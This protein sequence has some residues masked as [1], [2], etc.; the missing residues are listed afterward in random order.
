[1]SRFPRLVIC[2]TVLAALLVRPASAQV[3]VNVNVPPNPFAPAPVALQPAGQP[4]HGP[5][6]AGGYYGLPPELAR[7]LAQLEIRRRLIEQKRWEEENTP[8]LETLR[9]YWRQLAVQ[10]SLNDPPLSEIT[11]G[12]TLNVLLEQARRN[13]LARIEGPP[14]QLAPATLRCINVTTGSTTGGSAVV[15]ATED[16][17]W[18]LVLQAPRWQDLRLIIDTCLYNA[19]LEATSQGVQYDTD[20]KLNDAITQLDREVDGAVRA[21]TPTEFIQARRF[22]RQ[23]RETRKTLTEPGAANY[24]IGKWA[25]KADTVAELVQHMQ[26]TGLRFAPA[27]PGDEAAYRALHHALVCY[28]GSPPPLA[29]PALSTAPNPSLSRR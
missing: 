12:S 13:Q 29:V 19:T 16:V 11:S 26:T 5:Y 8:S 20:R 14:V 1:M 2:F 4:F 15:R 21:L 24:L 9:E 23:L 10:R 25:A 3:Q 7:A 6:G 17:K 22:V 28:V 27:L 18:P